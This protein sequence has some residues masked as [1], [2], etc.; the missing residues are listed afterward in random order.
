MGYM[1]WNIIAFVHGVQ[2]SA[3]NR[4]GLNRLWNFP[5]KSSLL[6]ICPNILVLLDN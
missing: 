3:V 5:S 1:Y 6:V 2:M 4:L